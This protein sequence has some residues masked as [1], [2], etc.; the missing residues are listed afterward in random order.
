MLQRTSW[1]FL[2]FR[3]SNDGICSGASFTSFILSGCHNKLSSPVSY[4]RACTTDTLHLFLMVCSKFTV[5]APNTSSLEKLMSSDCPVCRSASGRVVGGAVGREAGKQQTRIVCIFVAHN[6]LSANTCLGITWL[7]VVL[8]KM[9]ALKHSM[10]KASPDCHHKD[11]SP[12]PHKY[13]CRAR[14][15]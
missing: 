9:L 3:H 4:Q 10:L 1:N 13:V 14:C 7:F 8:M 5:E 15:F 2:G 11:S 6:S 12:V